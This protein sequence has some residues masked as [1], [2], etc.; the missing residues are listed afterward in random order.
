MR[1]TKSNLI[2]V[3]ALAVVAAVVVLVPACLS[4]LAADRP[5]PSEVYFRD[6]V[7]TAVA[8]PAWGVDA[9]DV[10]NV[11]HHLYEIV[12]AAVGDADAWSDGRVYSRVVTL[13]RDAR[14]RIDDAPGV[15]NPWYGRRR[16]FPTEIEACR[17]G[18]ADELFAK[19]VELVMDARWPVVADG[20]VD[21]RVADSAVRLVAHARAARAIA[22]AK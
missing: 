6:A 15:V 13:L 1:S 17:T 12:T 19:T 5:G 22:T 2:V 11:Q 7:P 14:S 20:D 8:Q 21:A 3:S 9:Y 10:P 18:R 16:A 4:S